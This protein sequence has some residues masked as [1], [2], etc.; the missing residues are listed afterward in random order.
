MPN[1]SNGNTKTI[2]KKLGVK[3]ENICF[4]ISERHEIASTS[5]L[6]ITLRHYQNENFC[7]AIDDFGSGYTSFA[8][9]QNFSAFNYYFCF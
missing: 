3:K 5:N 4:E 8:Y 2:L 1:F 7:I 9:L 6:E